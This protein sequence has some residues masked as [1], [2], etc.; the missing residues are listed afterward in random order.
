MVENFTIL[1]SARGYEFVRDSIRLTALVTPEMQ[2][3]LK[4]EFSFN[5]VRPAAPPEVFGAEIETSPPGLVCSYGRLATESEVVVPIRGLSF[6]AVRVVVDVAAPT[7]AIDDVYA[8]VREVV[9]RFSVYGGI[10]PIGEPERTREY[11]EV[12]ARLSHS[13]ADFLPD[14]VLEVLRD[15]FRE[16]GGRATG[17]IPSFSFALAEPDQDFPG[18]EEPMPVLSHRTGFA[19]SENQV[20]SAAY[21]DT[22]AH[23]A[24]LE[25]LDQAVGDCISSAD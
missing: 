8:K 5:S 16:V 6:D 19:P 17:M 14:P 21:L 10:A 23:R 11:S 1:A 12:T 18:M 25:K 7:S 15:G 24:Y 13:L 20:Y 2:A 3:A 9:G 22:D 4:A